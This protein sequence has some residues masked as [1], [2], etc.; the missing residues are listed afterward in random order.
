MRQEQSKQR[1]KEIDEMTRIRNLQAVTKKERRKQLQQTIVT[2]LQKQA[3]NEKFVKTWR[4]A[5]VFQRI[6]A[7]LTKMI[8]KKKEEAQFLAKVFWTVLKLK[9]RMATKLRRN[10]PTPEERLRRQIRHSLNSIG[11]SVHL[12]DVTAGNIIVNFFK[13]IETRVELKQ[14]II[15]NGKWVR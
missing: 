10:G 13:A 1:K 2:N 6:C 11:S 15:D 9:M 14:K 7:N 5:I 4:S 3:A 8:A 12:R